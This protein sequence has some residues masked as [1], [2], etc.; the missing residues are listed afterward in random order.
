MRSQS[1]RIAAQSVQAN[2][3]VGGPYLMTSLLTTWGNAP[4]SSF[5]AKHV[6]DRHNVYPDVPCQ[7]PISLIML[8]HNVRGGESIE[9]WARG[10]LPVQACTRTCRASISVAS[11]IGISMCMKSI[12][13]HKKPFHHRILRL[14]SLIALDS[15]R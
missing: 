11:G 4:V 1:R 15:L 14:S 2:I 12:T 6:F 9:L 7:A 8:V 5:M 10:A 3:P 13:S